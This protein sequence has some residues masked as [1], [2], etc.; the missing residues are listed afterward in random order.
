VITVDGSGF[1]VGVT[2]VF[3]GPNAGRN[4]QVFSPTQL[5]VRVPPAG[6]P[7]SGKLR[8]ADMVVDVTVQ[9][10]TASAT[11]PNA[12]TYVLPNRTH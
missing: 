4:V 11:L 9:L 12:Y 2:E 10:G 3:F 1:M 6:G 7:S 8:R 5:V